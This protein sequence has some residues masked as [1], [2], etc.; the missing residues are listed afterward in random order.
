LVKQLSK[1]LSNEIVSIDNYY[2][3][4]VQ[5][6]IQ[7]E[8]V[9]YVYCNTATLHNTD[10]VMKFGVVFGGGS[11][12]PQIICHPMGKGKVDVKSIFTKTGVLPIFESAEEADA[13]AF[14]FSKAQPISDWKNG[15]FNESSDPKRGAEEG[16]GGF[17]VRGAKK[18]NNKKTHACDFNLKSV[19]YWKNWVGSKSGCRVLVR[20]NRP[21]TRKG[22][23]LWAGLHT[24]GKDKIP[25]KCAVSNAW[26][27]LKRPEDEARAI[28]HILNSPLADT[29]IRSIGSKRHI[30]T[31]D[32]KKLGLP[33]LS[34][35]MIRDLSRR[36]LTFTEATALIFL[37]VFGL[38]K[39]RS[40]KFLKAT[41][42]V[43]KKEKAEIV[44]LIDLSA[45]QEAQKLLKSKPKRRQATTKTAARRA[46]R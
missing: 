15:E 8:N 12:G 18:C 45:K 5:N 7:A 43:S 24:P 25:K 33:K 4:S 9:K 41:A 29:A 3:G 23:V 13:Q 16:T 1:D 30:N 19:T 11:P 31:K 36:D 14:W 37:G 38:N 42:W 34:P 27:W 21:N 39:T 32:L 6:E 44:K 20:D 10:S 46:R 28:L 26:N 35:D 17:P 2:A 22:K 40:E